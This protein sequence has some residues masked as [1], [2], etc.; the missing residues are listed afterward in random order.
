MRNIQLHRNTVQRFRIR[1]IRRPQV[2]TEIVNV[3]AVAGNVITV[4]RGAA[5]TRADAHAAAAVVQT[6]PRASDC[7][8]IHAR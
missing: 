4:V 8:R 6:V 3:V 1:S 2:D 5:N 7:A